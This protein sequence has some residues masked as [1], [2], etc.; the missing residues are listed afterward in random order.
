[1][2]ARPPRA[3]HAQRAGQEGRRRAERPGPDREHLLPRPASPRSTRPTCAAGCAGGASTPSAARASTAARPR[4]S[5]RTSSTTST[6]C[7]GSA[8]TA[9]SSRTEQ[10]RVIAEVSH[11]VRPRHRR[12]HRPAERP[13]ALDPDRGRAGDLAAARGGRPVHD[14]GLRRH[15]AGRSSA[16]PSPASPPTR[17]STARPAIDAIQR[18]LHRLAGVLQ[19]AAQVQDRDQRLAAAGRRARGQRHLVRR[20]RAPRARPGLRPLGRRRPVDQPDAGPAARRLGAARR[21]ARR[22]GRRR[23]RVPRLRLPAAAH[24]GPDQVP[25]RRLGRREVPP[26]ARGRVPRPRADRRP[27]SP[28]AVR[29]AR[30]HRRA[31]AEGRPLLRRPGADGR[32]GLRHR[33]WP[34]SPTSPRQHGS[35]RVRTTPHQKLVV[36]DVA[37]RPGRLAG[38]RR[39]R[40]R[41]AGPAGHLPAQHDGLHRHRVLQA[42]DRRDQGPRRPS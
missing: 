4:S 22:L 21:G 8:S 7:C 13:A 33:C 39:R 25:G 16:P 6:S 19:P 15:P 24:P 2:G 35:H 18:A 41:P 34:G 32:P 30:P 1:M 26:G 20:R 42:G 17:S 40:A 12:R 28:G 36:L 27:G 9:A 10:L 23:R 31:P 37:R 3:A 11:R 29:L 14:R 38:R 5:S